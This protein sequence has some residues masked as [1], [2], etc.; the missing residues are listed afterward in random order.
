MVRSLFFL[1]YEKKKSKLQAIILSPVEYYQ[2]AIFL[3]YC[4][5][6]IYEN[7]AI[8]CSMAMAIAID[9]STTRAL[10]S[11]INLS[12]RQ[13]KLNMLRRTRTTFVSP[14][15]KVGTKSCPGCKICAHTVASTSVQRGGARVASCSGREIRMEL[16]EP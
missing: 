13:K 8:C 4:S 15:W 9:T 11:K 2:H 14:L 1:L 12:R 7:R 16:I 3:I 6:F 10:I 5:E